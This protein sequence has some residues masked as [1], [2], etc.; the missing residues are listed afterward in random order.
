MVVSILQKLLSALIIWHA[1]I[2]SVLAA[3]NDDKF[4]NNLMFL[5][6]LL[7]GSTKCMLMVDVERLIQSAINGMLRSLIRT[8]VFCPLEV[9]K[10]CKLTLRGHLEDLGLRLHLR[11]AL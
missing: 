6:R 10:T 3:E 9:M 4:I 1:I 2:G 8:Q 7:I 11:K 5:G